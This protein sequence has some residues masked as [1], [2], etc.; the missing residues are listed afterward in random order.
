MVVWKWLNYTCP[1][2][3][4]V[5][6]WLGSWTDSDNWANLSLTDSELANWN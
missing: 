1:D 3:W 6:G 4:G 2:N 5:A